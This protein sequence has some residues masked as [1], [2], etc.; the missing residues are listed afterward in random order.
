MPIT[1]HIWSRRHACMGSRPWRSTHSIST[2]KC[3]CVRVCEARLHVKTSLKNT[4]TISTTK[5]EGE[6]ERGRESKCGVCDGC[7]CVRENRGES[8]AQI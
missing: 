5:R 7:S 6:R 1:S 4:H 3:V 8:H 2:T